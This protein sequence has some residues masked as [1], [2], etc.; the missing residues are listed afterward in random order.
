MYKCRKAL[1]ILLL[2]S[3]CQKENE[4]PL[5]Q[6][7]ETKASL[8]KLLHSDSSGID[9]ENRLKPDEHF[10][11]LEYNYFYNGGGVAIGDLNRDGLPDIFLGGNMESSR[12]YL[13]K[14]N[15]KFEDITETSGTTTRQ[16]ISG[17]SIVDVNADGWNDIYLCASGFPESEK[18]KNLLFINQQAGPDGKI[19][20]KEMAAAY[21]LDDDGYSTQATWLDY[22]RDGDLD[23][24][25]LSHFHDKS[26]PNIPKPK[27]LKGSPGSIDRLYENTGIGPDGHPFFRNVGQQA[28]IT[29]EGYGL[30]VAIDDFNQDGWPDIYV[31]NDFIYDDLLYINQ[32]KGPDGKVTF[33]ESA[34]QYFKHSSR[35]AMG[36]DAA[37]INNDLWPDIFTLDMLPED[38]RRKKLM[39]TAMNYDRYMLALERA[40]LPQFSRNTL[41]INQGQFKDEV[42][43]FS[44][45][46]RLAGI[47]ETDWSWSALWADYD[48]DSY[49]DLLVT[50]GI[51]KDITDSDF[52]KFRDT[53]VYQGDFDYDLL[54]KELLEKVDSLPGVDKSNFIFRNRKDLNFSDMTTQWGLRRP[55]YSNGAAYADLDHDGDLDLVISNID[56]PVFVYQNQA[57]LQR[58]GHFLQFRLHGPAANRQGIGTKLILQHNGQQQYYYHSPARGFQSWV[59][60]RIHAGLGRDS[61]VEQL[62][63]IWPDQQQQVLK[64]VS[65][66]QLLELRHEDAQEAATLFWST[67]HE[68]LLKEAGTAYG[69]NHTHQENDFADFKLEPLLPHKLSQNGPGLAVAD[70]N[71]DGLD[72]FWIGGAHG[73]AGSLYIQTEN[74]KF[75]KRELED[76]NFEDM[77]GLFF[78]A[79]N[80]GD[81]DLYVVSGGNEFNANTAAYQ[82]R[83]Y[84]NDG[85]GNFSRNKAALPR[86]YSSGSCVAAADFDQDGDLD[87]FVGGR[88]T[89]AHYPMPP[90]SYLLQNEGGVFREVSDLLAPGLK[91]V[92]MVTTALWTDVDN[93]GQTDLMLAG[94]WMPLTVFKNKNGR[95]E[96]VTQ[97]AGL[98]DSHGWWNSLIG[99]DFDADGDIDYVAG[100]LGLNTPLKAS[101]SQPVSI[102]ANDFDRNGSIDALLSHYQQGVEVPYVS[103]DPLVSQLV[104]MRKRFPSYRSYAEADMHQ[105]LTDSER[106]QAY[107]ARAEVMATSYLENLG[108]GRLMIRPLPY[109]AQMAPIYGMLSGDFNQDGKTDLLLHGNSYATEFVSGQYDALRGLVLLGDGKGFFTALKAA[110]S[111]FIADYDATALSRLSTR[112]GKQLVLAAANNDTLR[113]FEAKA[114]TLPLSIQPGD[115]YAL[116][117]YRDGSTRKVEFYYG[118]SYLSQSGWS[119]PA[120][121]SVTKI[122]IVDFKGQSREYIP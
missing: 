90:Q 73:Q 54:K 92:G 98:A 44:E 97:Q 74:G 46:G 117:Q 41:Q 88:L 45:A 84:L 29:H 38:N 85:Q 111:G 15:L 11:I 69:L 1:I 91:Q 86:L 48:N 70:V 42:I 14:G 3:A 35:F 81:P 53:K 26:N 55:S 110:E 95:L 93:D 96:N 106:R 103:L 114:S 27:N 68:P 30:G 107:K 33:K 101:A 77:G 113:V 32:Q 94:E 56:A 7:T 51:P 79:D 20:F 112:Q 80:D 37:D 116:L 23:M 122:V 83:L 99:A 61:L 9:F 119:L 72:D 58:K 120:D 63:I 49:K 50:N 82:D 39:N 22:D 5:V 25:L 24:Y 31:S 6:Q 87:L 65:A 100:N 75:R 118:E 108:D 10:N 12:L 17:V 109:Q 8:F 64:N 47:H 18:R 89:P 59:D 21:G 66:D 2:L 34:H 57:Q 121:S 67:H 71:G 36:T 78:D 52:I 16:W 19:T 40:Y 13:N 43:A 62:T 76:K 28:G 4:K 104:M 102:T 60:E 105:V 115:A